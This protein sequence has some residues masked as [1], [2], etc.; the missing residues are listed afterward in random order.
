[1]LACG[2]DPATTTTGDSTGDSTGD[3]TPT[4]GAQTSA[5][6]TTGA[7]PI[8]DEDGLPQPRP[9]GTQRTY[10]LQLDNV[11]E[12]LDT[13]QVFFAA[14]PGLCGETPQVPCPDDATPALMS[15]YV[16]LSPQ[17]RKPGV[18]P[19]SDDIFSDDIWV[20]AIVTRG[21][22]DDC[23]L[24]FF[25]A[26][27]DGTVEVLADDGACISVDVRDVTPT[28]YKGLTLDPNGSGHAPLCTP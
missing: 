14:G 3:T 9:A 5:T 13:A 2:P 17:H 4:G 22:P 25:S 7:V 27:H 15:Y 8:C 26:A 19:I 23:D 21:P 20:G 6:P 11:N 28:D 1:M 10:W 18:Y 16:V 24:E 12:P